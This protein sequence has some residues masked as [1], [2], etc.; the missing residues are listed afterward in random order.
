MDGIEILYADGFD[1]TGSGAIDTEQ[2]KGPEY[3]FAEKERRSPFTAA[4]I[5]N[6]VEDKIDVLLQKYDISIAFASMTPP[7][8][9]GQSTVGR[10]AYLVST[11]DA[12]Q[13]DKII[14]EFVK[15]VN[16]TFTEKRAFGRTHLSLGA[17]LELLPYRGHIIYVS[18]NLSDYAHGKELAAQ[19]ATQ[20]MQ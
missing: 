14:A 2:Q 6:G 7:T 17:E 11:T 9:R 16:E 13:A 19:R 4:A 12:L 10:P 3:I 20:E 18:K 15:E 1:G 5:A 8:D